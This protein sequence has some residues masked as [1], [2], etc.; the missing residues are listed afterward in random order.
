MT[1]PIKFRAWDGVTKKMYYNAEDGVTIDESTFSFGELARG[2]QDSIA[3]MQFT[4]LLDKNGKEIYE[5]DVL[6]CAYTP[7][8]GVTG[9]A[10]FETSHGY[11]IRD[12]KNAWQ[13]QLGAKSSM[14]IIGNIYE[15]PSLIKEPK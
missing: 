4:G 13:G 11:G 6:R 7:D 14:E 10:V 2:G 15:N 8:S 5:G 1:R 12:N 3:L 9:V